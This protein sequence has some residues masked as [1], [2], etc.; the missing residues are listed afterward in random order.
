MQATSIGLPH[1][2]HVSPVATGGPTIM[3]AD[4]HGSN[5]VHITLPAL[6]TPACRQVAPPMFD[7]VMYLSHETVINNSVYLAV[8]CEG[9]VRVRSQWC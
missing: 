6:V 7:P 3:V 2:V 5:A 9:Q 8:Y 1:A 4:D